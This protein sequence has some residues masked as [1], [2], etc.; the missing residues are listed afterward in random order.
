MYAISYSDVSMILFSQVEV[1]SIFSKLKVSHLA[2]HKNEVVKVKW[3]PNSTHYL[4]SGGD[5]GIKIT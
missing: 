2:G 1:Y 3:C 5:R 4:A